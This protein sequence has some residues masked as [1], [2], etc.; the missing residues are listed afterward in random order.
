VTAPSTRSVRALR[1]LAPAAALVCLALCLRGPFAAVGPLV[2]DLSREYE[3]GTPAVAALTAAPLLCFALGSPVAP[4]LA[5]RLG[6]L[7]AVLCGAATVAVGVAARAAGAQ[8]LFLGTVLL[9]LGIA[10][11][12]VL[13]PALVREQYGPRSPGVLGATTASIAVS[14]SLGAGLAQPLA[15]AT[16]SARGSLTAWL[17]P[18]VLACVA[19]ALVRTRPRPESGPRPGQ[20]R[21]WSVLPTDRVAVAV[22]SYFGL[23]S[24]SFYVMLTWLPAVLQDRTATS[25]AGAGALLAVAAALGAPA[26]LLVP[27]LAAR[28]AGQGGWVVAVAAPSAMALLGLL[29]AADAAPVL[30]VL[31]YGLGTG[32]AFPL[33]LTLVVLRT[34]DAL[35]TGQLSA[36]AQSIGYLVAAAGPLGVGLLA[37]A[38]GGWTVPLLALLGLLGAQT[39]VGLA[40]GR[41][42]LVRPVGPS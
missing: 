22:T 24:L 36:S 6:L 17:V 20:R 18:A 5:V 25:P 13:L 29:L 14:A 35:E 31:L 7:R 39:A 16:G 34:R 27:R 12:N 21:R 11:V 38:S 32:A 28:S 3:I 15:A 42:R 40:A 23:Q 30:W 19:V 2:D 4:L 33:A 26:S 8:G 10:V 1:P 37:D 9:A 41:P